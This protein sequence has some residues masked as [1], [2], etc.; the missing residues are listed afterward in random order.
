MR[1]L[2][3]SFN[4]AWTPHFETELELA[5]THLQVGDAVEFLQCDGCSVAC[6]GNPQLI[7]LRCEECKSIFSTGLSTLSA[8]VQKHALSDYD[9]F[10][11]DHPELHKIKSIQH[12]EM[13]KGFRPDDQDLGWGGYSS[14]IQATRDYLGESDLAKQLLPKFVETAFKTYLAV[15]KFL[16][17]SSTYDVVYIFNG[18]FAGPKAAWRACQLSKKIGDIRLH[19]RGADKTKYHFVHDTT[20][21]DRQNFTRSI[22]NN[23]NNA[24]PTQRQNLGELFYESRRQGNPTNWTSFVDRQKGGTLPKHFDPSKKNIAI[25]NSSEDEFAGVGP[26]WINPI[27]SS[28]SEAII[29]IAKDLLQREPDTHLYLR[30]HPNL[31]GVTHSDA[32]KTNAIR[33]PNVTTIAADS[34]IC[35]YALL[36]QVDKVLSFGST[37]GVEATYAGKPSIVAGH[38][39]YENLDAAYFPQTHEEVLHLLQTDLAPKPVENAIKFGYHCKVFGEEFKYYQPDTIFCGKFTPSSHWVSL[40]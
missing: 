10:S 35:T 18:R 6:D 14:T 15:S 29:R 11:D 32:I 36:E 12:P 20:V 31:I 3:I 40:I 34:P 25:F 22:L 24:D 30:I 37:M 13:A 17:C 16:E 7:P 2:F 9:C 1:V 33:L 4:T 26:E 8:K 21:H 19:E 23:W 27:Y 5:E 38:S 28:Q 39:L